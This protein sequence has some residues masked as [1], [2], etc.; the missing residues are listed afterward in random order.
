[1]HDPF[2]RLI[3]LF[4]AAGQHRSTPLFIRP[5]RIIEICDGEI[6]V[7]GKGS[8]VVSGKADELHTQVLAKLAENRQAETLGK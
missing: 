6:F 1:M 2:L 7:E 3:H 4:S 5:E 8:Y